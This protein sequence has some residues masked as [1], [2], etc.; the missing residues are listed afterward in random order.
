MWIQQSISHFM[1]P[2]VVLMRSTPSRTLNGSYVCIDALFRDVKK[3]HVVG[4]LDFAH[5]AHAEVRQESS[6]EEQTSALIRGVFGET[7]FDTKAI[8]LR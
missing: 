7:I 3:P 8:E 1:V 4:L 2:N 5:D 6:G